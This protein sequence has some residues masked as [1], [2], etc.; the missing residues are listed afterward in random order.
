MDIRYAAVCDIGKCRSENQD[1]VFT[2]IGDGWG[3]FIVADGM[4]GHSDGAWASQTITASFAGWVGGIRERLP[5]MDIP[6][7]FS[8]LRE[9]LTEANKKIICHVKE[10]EICGS[11]VVVLL[12]VHESYILLSVGDSRCYELRKKFLRASVHQMTT[13]EI[14]ECPGKNYGKLTN[15]VGTKQQLRCQ[16]VSGELRKKHTFFLC[17]DGVYKFCSGEELLVIMRSGQRETSQKTE[18]KIKKLINEK[19]A[20]DNFSAIFVSVRF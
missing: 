14:C 19:G 7:L 20:E 8:E 10:G 16:L 15:A 1:A 6:E 5:H 4:G 17:S 18:E 2:E 13:D 12:L 9:V 3:I 11:T